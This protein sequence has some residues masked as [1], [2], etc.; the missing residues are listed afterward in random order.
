MA[1]QL[2]T[3]AGSIPWSRWIFAGVL[4]VISI[5][6]MWMWLSSGQAAANPLSF[7]FWILSA[8]FICLGSCAAKGPEDRLALIAASTAAGS[9]LIAM[10]AGLVVG[11]AWVYASVPL[12]IGSLAQFVPASAAQR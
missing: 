7:A 6:L 1:Q 4:A 5:G 2:E 12:L 11:G 8:A 10:F 3:P 9:A